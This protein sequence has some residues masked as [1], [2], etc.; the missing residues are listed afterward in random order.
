M[1]ASAESQEMAPVSPAQHEEFA[2]QY[3]RRLL[4]KF[5]LN[6]YG[7]CDGLHDKMEHVMAIPHIRRIS[8]SPFA[9]VSVCAQK[10]KG[11]YIYSWKPNPVYLSNP[12]FN[13]ESVREYMA[14]T[15]DLTKECVVEIILADTHTCHNQPERFTQW[16]KIARELVWKYYT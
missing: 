13:P 9:D 8:I 10:L 3:E 4:S 11:D 5:G 6:G 12:T 7:C 1:W 15:I 2:M 16:V 14:Q